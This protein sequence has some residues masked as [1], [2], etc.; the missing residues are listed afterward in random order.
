M[1]EE[2]KKKIYKLYCELSDIRKR[3]AKTFEDNILNELQELGMKKANFEI[4][5][6]SIP[7]YEDCAF[8]SAN[9]IDE[10]EFMLSANLG[11]PLKNLSM[12]ISGGEMSR[13][14]LSIKT[15]TAK[16][17]DIS[18]FIF[19]EIDAGISGNV[20]RIVAEKFAQ[21][22]KSTQIIAITHLPQISAMA[23]NNLLI[24]KNENTSKTITTVKKLTEQEKVLEIV[25]LTGGSPNS[26][27][28]ID[29]ANDV[30]NNALKFKNAI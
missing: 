10:I 13:F 25:R 15:Q 22:S 7:S 14:M 16:Y 23:D 8:L 19:D 5:F 27:T 17:N 2:L 29:H 30:I 18:T 26:Q 24:E 12:V 4:C 3:I 11:E 20:A 28:A 9:G 21:I 6:N 1:I